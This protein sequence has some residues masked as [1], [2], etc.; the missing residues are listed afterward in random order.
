MPILRCSIAPARPPDYS[1]ITIS[2]AGMSTIPLRVAEVE[3][4]LHL[5]RRRINAF[6]LQHV[7]FL[8]SSVL[9]LVGAALITAGLRGSAETFR[10]AAWAGLAVVLTTAAL[11]IVVLATRWVDLRHAAALADR[12]SGL[13]DRLTTLISVRGKRQESR[14]APLLVTQILDMRASWRPELVAPR[15]MPRTVFVLLAS[16]ALLAS[17]AFLERRSIE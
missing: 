17:T 9:V 7:A 8:G 15:A 4:R 16:L 14:L 5:V 6:T 2:A 3:A 12:R 13:S 1:S 11:C 10:I